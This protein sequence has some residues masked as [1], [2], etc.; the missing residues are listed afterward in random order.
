MRKVFNAHTE[1]DEFIYPATIKTINLEALNCDNAKKTP[2]LRTTV[3]VTYPSGKVKTHGAM[4]WE[5]SYNKLPNLYAVGCAVDLAVQIDGEHK[6]KAKVQLPELELFEFEEFG[7]IL[8]GETEGVET[9]TVEE[10]A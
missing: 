6:G 9:K 1:Q 8:A 7:D 5:A 3:E 10:T 2:F 4:L